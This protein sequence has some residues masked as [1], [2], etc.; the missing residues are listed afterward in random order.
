MELDARIFIPG[1]SGL[2]GS[3]ICRRLEAGGYRDLIVRSHSQL[4][5]SRRQEVDEF[6]AREKPEYVFLCAAKV[7]GIHANDTYPVDFLLENLKIQNNV[8]EAA[9]RNSVKGLLF[10]GSSCIYPGEAPQPLREDYLLTGPLEPTNRAYAIAKIAGIEL[11]K[12]FNRQHHTRFLSV[13]PTNLYGP[14]DRYDL[15]NSHLVPALI[16]KFHLGKLAAQ[17]DF[18]AIGREASCYGPIPRDIL[19]GL[20][21]DEGPEVRLWGTGAPMRELLHSDDMADAC[22]FLMERAEGLF[23][24]ESERLAA[25]PVFNVG[26]GRDITIRE[27]AHTVAGVVGFSGRVSWDPSKPDGTLRKLLDVSRMRE[28]GWES[29][30]SLEEGL[31]ATYR[32]YVSKLSRGCK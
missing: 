15:E 4:D 12:A 2:A 30:I 27:L 28:L 32:D 17:K 20:E 8:I 31:R 13:M 23:E 9:F 5:L 14:N 25:S 22:V 21:K 18:A 16:R 26:A 24:G 19:E 7:G 3:A 10:L 29:K 11:C 1:H 6:F